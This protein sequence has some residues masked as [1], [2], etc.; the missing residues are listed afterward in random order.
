MRMIVRKR[1]LRV[2]AAGATMAM[3]AIGS[4]AVAAGSHP[5]K[6][7]LPISS[8]GG[9]HRQ[10]VNITMSSTKEFTAPRK[11]NAGWVT[12]RVGAADTD[13]HGLEVARPNPGHTLAEVINDLQMGLGSDPASEALGARNLVR[14]GTLMGG[15]VTSSYAPMEATLPLTP[16][17]YYLFDFAEFG[18]PTPPTVHTMRVVGHMDWAGM[19]AFHSVVGMYM[20][21]QD[22]PAFVAPTDFSATGSFLVYGQGDELHEAVFRPTKPGITDQYISDYY[23]AIDAGLPHAPSPWTDIQHGFNAMSPGQ[24]AVFHLDLPPGPYALICY[25]PSDDTGLPHAHMGMHQ[26]VTLH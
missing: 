23:A 4:P 10:T 12:F 20:N 11:V 22:M 13:Y 14:D 1:T 8:W 2:A 18:L 24:F 3:L 5:G 9:H 7:N 16:G 19:P 25:V 21:P 15:V 26:M 6:V 17:T